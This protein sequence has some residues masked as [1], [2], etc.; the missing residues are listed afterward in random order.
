MHAQGYLDFL[1]WTHF[2]SV[3]KSLQFHLFLQDERETPQQGILADVVLSV[4]KKLSQ[5]QTELSTLASSLGAD[6]RWVYDES[7]TH[8]I[9]QVRS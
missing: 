4:S 9:H 6:Y 3:C 1:Q 5:Q 7:C 8:L 2:L